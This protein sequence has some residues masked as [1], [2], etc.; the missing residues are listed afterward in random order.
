MIEWFVFVMCRVCWMCGRIFFVFV[1]C[2]LGIECCWLRVCWLFGSG[3]ESWLC[4]CSGLSWWVCLWIVW[5]RG[6]GLWCW[7]VVFWFFGWLCVGD[8]FCW[9]WCCCRGRVGCSCVWDFWWWCGWWCRWIGLSYWWWMSWIGSVGW[10]CVFVLELV[11]IWFVGWVCCWLKIG[12]WICVFVDWWWFGWWLF[13]SFFW[14]CLGS[15]DWVLWGWVFGIFLS[16]FG[17][18]WIR[19]EICLLELIFEV[20]FED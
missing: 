6:S 12:F 18:V 14:V 13:G 7:V 16:V 8:G 4:V 5:W 19:F 11:L 2:W 20:F 3:C 10:R 15:V 17:E 9:D 1:F